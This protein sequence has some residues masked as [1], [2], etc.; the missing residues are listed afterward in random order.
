MKGRA[1]PPITSAYFRLSASVLRLAAAKGARATN[2][3]QVRSL[4][5]GPAS[6][7]DLHATS[8]V[9]TLAIISHW[10]FHLTGL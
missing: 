4:L 9:C 7:Q 1:I 8:D 3:T 5:A 2:A 6:R 10:A